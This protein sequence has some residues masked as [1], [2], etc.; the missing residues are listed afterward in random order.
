MALQNALIRETASE[1]LLR[2]DSNVPLV[3]PS[4]RALLSANY[5]PSRSSSLVPDNGLIPGT[6]GR[7]RL[8]AAGDKLREL[9]IPD[10]LA[11]AVGVGGGGGRRKGKLSAGDEVKIEKIRVELDGLLAKRCPLCEGVQAGVDQGF[12]EVGEKEEAV[13]AI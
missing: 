2:Q 12:V 3:A 8:A 11:N 6:G 1:D 7:N 13:W 9:I 10:A 4:K 5:T